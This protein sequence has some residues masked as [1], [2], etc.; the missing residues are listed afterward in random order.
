[1]DEI[2]HGVTGAKVQSWKKMSARSLLDEI[3]RSHPGLDEEGLLHLFEAECAPY[4][5]EIVAYWVRNNLRALKPKQ[6]NGTAPEARAAQQEQIETKVAERIVEVTAKLQILSLML[7]S[8]VT[9]GDATADQL[10]EAGGQYCK[11]AAKLREKGAPGAKAR[12]VF[13]EEESWAALRA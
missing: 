7:P 6:A 11:L 13:T 9:V 12:E 2:D 4:F 3:V 8:G 10:D 5:P 1:M